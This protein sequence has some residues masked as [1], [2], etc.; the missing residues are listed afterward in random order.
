MRKHHQLGRLL[1]LVAGLA[2]MLAF[3]ATQWTMQPKESKLTFVGTQAGAQFE[4]AFE[5]F[6]ADIKFDPQDLPAAAS[7]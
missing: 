7:T 3:A 2:A 1:V 6:T 5:K 4:G